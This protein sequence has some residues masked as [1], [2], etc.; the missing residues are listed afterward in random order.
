MSDRDRT[1]NWWYTLPGI[2]TGIAAIITAITGF[3][4]GIAQL[5]PDRP[6]DPQ[7]TLQLSESASVHRPSSRD[8]APPSEPPSSPQVTP[9]ADAQAII[10][11]MNGEVV[12][13]RAE[14][15]SNCISVNH[16]LAL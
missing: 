9:W 11:S 6:E 7:Q 12:T 13:V 3:A 8:N 1:Q 5:R 16:S 4:V 14:T 2:L 10:T 15:F